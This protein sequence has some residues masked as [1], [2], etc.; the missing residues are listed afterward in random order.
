MNLDVQNLRLDGRLE[1]RHSW[2]KSVTEALLPASFVADVQALYD[3]RERV[4]AGVS[5]QFSTAQSNGAGFEIPWYAD[6]GG[7]AEYAFNR[8]ISLWLRGGNLLN[9]EIQRNPLYAEKGVNFTAGISLI[10]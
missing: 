10:F 5:C 9:M 3:W 7:C 6:L 8:N 4:S 2:G 1:Y